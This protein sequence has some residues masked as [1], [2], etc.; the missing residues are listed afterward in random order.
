VVAL[1]AVLPGKRE[2][3][4]LAALLLVFLA[5]ARHQASADDQSFPEY[6]K[7]VHTYANDAGLGNWTLLE[8]PMF[9]VLVNESQILIGQNW[10]IVCPLRANQSYHVYCYGDW[11]S[12]GS[13]PVTDYDLYVYNP[14]GGLEGYHTESAGLP[15][16]LGTTVSEPFFMPRLSG[17]YTFVVRNDPRESSGAQKA[18]F[19]VVEDV[20]CNAWHQ[21]YVEGK[22][23]GSMPVFNTSWAY[24][25]YAESQRVE[26]WVRV[27]ET[28]DMYEVRLYLMANTEQ[29]KGSLLNGVPLAWEQ[30]LYGNRSDK[31]G[32][33]NLESEEY[34]GAAYASCEFSGEDMFIN[35]TS[36]YRGASLYHL[37]LIGEAGE[38]NVDFLVKTEFGKAS[39]NPLIVPFRVYPHNNTVVAYTCNATNLVNAT[40]RYSVDGW[41]NSTAV[42]MEI[43]GNR[44]CRAAVPAQEAGSLVRYRVEAR[45]VFESTLKANGSYPVKHP[46]T[47]N[48]SLPRKAVTM[49]EN[50]TVKGYVTPAAKGLEVLL[51][52]SA[53]NQTTVKVTTFENGSFVASCRL[54]ALGPWDVQATLDE[55]N[56]RF[57]CVS[58]ILTVRVEEPS[59]FAKYG[60]FIGGGLGAAAAVG[61]VVY[62][63]KFRE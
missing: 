54:D 7:Y 41:R 26:V 8:K 13:E 30:G 24:E 55:D 4:V 44:T 49:G 23:G 28:L 5:F 22:D 15:E 50:V 53:K 32:G 10:S 1:R 59:V 38:G 51:V 58:G 9:P 31:I 21:H 16:H 61:A 18:T 35:F 62:V 46:V 36:P 45:D 29:K 2:L 48:M 39:L 34:R 6:R 63:K 52:F 56:L 19:M 43:V 42:E 37:V 27:P 17:N 47:L 20:E 3:A 14:L 40:L 60:L 11:V 33:Y 57:G 12:N 25:F